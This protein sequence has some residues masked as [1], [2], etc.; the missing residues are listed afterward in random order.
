WPFTNY[1]RVVTGALP[2]AGIAAG[3]WPFREYTTPPARAN[4]PTPYQTGATPR[5]KTSTLPKGLKARP[6][7]PFHI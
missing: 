1:F 6:I 7:P 5:D 2:Q 3:L 4:G